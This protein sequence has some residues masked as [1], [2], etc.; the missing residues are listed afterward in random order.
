MKLGPM[1]FRSL[2]N[3][4]LL[5]LPIQFIYTALDQLTS[6]RLENALMNKVLFQ[7]FELVFFGSISIT[8][9]IFFPLLASLISYYFIG[10]TAGSISSPVSIFFKTKLNHYLI[11]NIRAWGKILTY[12][13]F[14]LLPG[15]LQWLKLSFVPLI[16][17]FSE[18]Y[19]NGKIDALK[20]SRSLTANIRIRIFLLLML[21]SFFLPAISTALFDDHRQLFQDPFSASSV[22]FIEATLAHLFCTIIYKIYQNQKMQFQ[23]MEKL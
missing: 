16:S 22:I 6:T 18:D 1:Y 20:A 10:R 5:L 11:E 7:N 3:G 2:R 21:F 23:T 17:L 14:F 8:L 12:S 19:E 9:N 13:L 15:L 4:L